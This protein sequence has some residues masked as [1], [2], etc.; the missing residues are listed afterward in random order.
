MEGKHEQKD[1]AEVPLDSGTILNPGSGGDY[2]NLECS[3]V[4]RNVHTCKRHEIS[5]EI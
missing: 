5:G 1:K 4:H 3:I 2:I